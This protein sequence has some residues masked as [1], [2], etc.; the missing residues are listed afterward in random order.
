MLAQRGGLEL[1]STAAQGYLKGLEAMRGA[2]SGASARSDSGSS[3]GPVPVPEG[4][5]EAATADLEAIGDRIADDDLAREL[6]AQ[7]ERVRELQTAG[8]DLDQ[9]ER[10]E[11]LT[12]LLE[13]QTELLRRCREHLETNANGE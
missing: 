2:G 5:L 1:A 7:R 12:A 8:D 11:R 3:S 4:S 10:V 6:A 9:R 13:R